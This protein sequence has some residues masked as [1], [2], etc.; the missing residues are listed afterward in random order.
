MRGFDRQFQHLKIR[1]YN[2][3]RKTAFMHSADRWMAGVR[4]AA[5]S[6]YTMK[7]ERSTVASWAF[8]TFGTVFFI[9]FHELFC[10]SRR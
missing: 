10:N 6:N 7:V 5:E 4:T 2:V 3:R 8:G 9:A 1:K